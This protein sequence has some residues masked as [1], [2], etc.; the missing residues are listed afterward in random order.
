M[1]ENALSFQLI[2]EFFLQVRIL[3]IEVTGSHDPIMLHLEL[4]G[5]SKGTNL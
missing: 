2:D 5:V 4:P 1:I 3:K